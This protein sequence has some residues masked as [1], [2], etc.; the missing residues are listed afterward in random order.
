MPYAEPKK[1][2]L[3]SAEKGDLN[4]KNYVHRLAFSRG[5]RV[6]SHAG[7]FDPSLSTLNPTYSSLHCN[8]FPFGGY[9]LGPIKKFWLNQND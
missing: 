9:L 5:L 3:M 4:L 7:L 8:Y 2:T 6:R 1:V